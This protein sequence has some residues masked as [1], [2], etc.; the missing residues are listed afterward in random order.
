MIATV[1]NYAL[2]K[3][4]ATKGRGVHILKPSSKR[5]RIQADM[6]DQYNVDQFFDVVAKE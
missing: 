3:I 6:D 5:R 1:V 4:T 2:L